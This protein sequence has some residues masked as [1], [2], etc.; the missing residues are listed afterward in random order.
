MA[1]MTVMVMAFWNPRGLTNKTTELK[2]FMNTEEVVYTGLSETQTYKQDNELSC[3]RFRYDSGA[4][5]VPDDHGN[6]TSLTGSGIGAYIDTTKSA[7]GWGEWV[8]SQC[9]TLRAQ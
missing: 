7:Q 1:A 8:A 6:S 5:H 2:D 9:A 4:E 3:G